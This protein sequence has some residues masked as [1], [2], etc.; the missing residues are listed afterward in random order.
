MGAGGADAPLMLPTMVGWI[1]QW[2]VMALPLD[3]DSVLLVA[4]GAMSPESQVP[5]SATR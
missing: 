3:T 2:K 1:V 4:P 5:L